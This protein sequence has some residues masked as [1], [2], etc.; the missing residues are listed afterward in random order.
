M[1]K[2]PEYVTTEEIVLAVGEQDRQVLP[3]NSCVKPIDARYVSKDILE[4]WTR[5]MGWDNPADPKVFVY[6]RFG[7][8]RIKKSLIRET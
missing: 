5:N 3:V 6:C 4:K 7:L 8:K 2:I 1:A